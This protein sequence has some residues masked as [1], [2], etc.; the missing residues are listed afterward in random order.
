MNES[1][2]RGTI[3]EY[4]DENGDVSPVQVFC[5]AQVLVSCWCRS[6]VWVSEQDDAEITAPSYPSVDK[7]TFL[8]HRGVLE[9]LIS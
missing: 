7:V 4:Y 6:F 1:Q 8:Y 5:P 3:Q 9:I 2:W